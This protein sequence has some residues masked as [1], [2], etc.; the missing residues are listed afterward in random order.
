VEEFGF[1][2]SENNSFEH[3]KISCKVDEQLTDKNPKSKRIEGSLQR[4]I[5]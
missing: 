1:L 5:S 4:L 2:G 3:T